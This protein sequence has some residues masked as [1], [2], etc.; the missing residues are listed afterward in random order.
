MLNSC[1]ESGQVLNWIWQLTK[2]DILHR[3]L[4]TDV[5]LQS[6]NC[7]IRI[8]IFVDLRNVMENTDA[9]L[10]LFRDSPSVTPP[11][12]APDL[13]TIMQ[14]FISQFNLTLLFDTLEHVHWCQV[15]HV[16]GMCSALLCS[17]KASAYHSCRWLWWWL[18]GNEAGYGLKARATPPPIPSSSNFQWVRTQRVV[19]VCLVNVLLTCI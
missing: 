17:P 8:S 4:L 11:W 12:T 7:H 13:V 10:Y 19:L 5:H 3:V 6:W 16:L 14:Y 18:I 1:S 2:K 15:C 9:A